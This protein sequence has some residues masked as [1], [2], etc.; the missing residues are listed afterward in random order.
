MVESAFSSLLPGH[1]G[2]SGHTHTIPKLGIMLRAEQYNEENF[3]P[4][5]SI[6]GAG[7]WEI[8]KDRR[9]S[10]KDDTVEKLRLLR[11][12]TILLWIHDWLQQFRSGQSP[13]QQK[14]GVFQIMSA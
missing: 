5:T 6:V 9:C 13:G 14:G 4:G 2:T 1:H 3:D 7:T 12:C 11:R 10:V 8:Q